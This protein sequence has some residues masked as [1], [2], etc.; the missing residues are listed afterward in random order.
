MQE[1]SQEIV[2]PC[3]SAD[4]LIR[5][6]ILAGDEPDIIEDKDLGLTLL[7]YSSTL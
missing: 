4:E 6:A 7:D 3:Y 5:K 1:D 2:M